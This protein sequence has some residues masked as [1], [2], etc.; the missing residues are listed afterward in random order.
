MLNIDM[1]ELFRYYSAH[2]YEVY[3]YI[4]MAKRISF[5]KRIRRETYRIFD[6]VLDVGNAVIEK[7]GVEKILIA[8]SGGGSLGVSTSSGPSGGNNIH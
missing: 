3:G 6:Q 5:L 7:T 4:S 2:R 1:H 8:V